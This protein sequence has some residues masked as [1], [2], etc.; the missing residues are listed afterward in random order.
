QGTR[1]EL[2]TWNLVE[3]VCS[4]LKL[5]ELVKIEGANHAFKAGKKDIMQLLVDTTKDWVEKK[6]KNI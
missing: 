1:D 2:A 3:S 4:S 5:A 6:I